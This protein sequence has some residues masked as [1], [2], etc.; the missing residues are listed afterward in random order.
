LCYIYFIFTCEIHFFNITDEGADIADE[1][2]DS[3][4]KRSWKS[5]E[6]GAACEYAFLPLFC[7]TFNS[8][9][10]YISE[11]GILNLMNWY[12]NR[13]KELWC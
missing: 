8:L 3:N 11:C 12:F 4:S 10:L 7:Y 9:L 5:D 2:A 13:K 1:E 6:E